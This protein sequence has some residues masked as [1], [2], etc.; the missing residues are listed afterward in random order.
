MRVA[1]PTRAR[2]NPRMDLESLRASYPTDRLRRADLDPDPGAQFARWYE[3]WRATGVA[4]P[5]AMALATADTAGRPSVRMV[6][7]KGVDARGFRFFTNG[8]SRKARE[9]R[10][11][12][13]A[14]LLFYQPALERQVR[15]EGRVAPIDPSESDAYFATRPRGSQLGA[16]ASPQSAP[17]PDRAALEARLADVARRHAASAAPIPRPPHWGGYRLAPDRFEFWQGRGDRLH[18][19]FEYRRDDAA[20]WTI[21]RLAP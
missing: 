16:W 20:G 9:L 5:E 3:A 7:L 14:A 10:V 19:R 13:R 2:H 4:E 12:P 8:E 1:A 18:D 11:N 15:V 6:L 17:L 21:V